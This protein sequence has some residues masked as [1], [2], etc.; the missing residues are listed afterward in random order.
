MKKTIISKAIK[1]S[2]LYAA[3]FGVSYATTC[4]SDIGVPALP[5]EISGLYT[6]TNE[7]ACSD[8]NITPSGMLNST[9]P[10]NTTGNFFIANEGELNILKGGTASIRNYGAAAISGSYTSYRIENNGQLRN[11]GAIFDSKIIN[12]TN[13][14]LRN[15]ANSTMYRTEIDNKGLFYNAGLISRSFESSP[16][17]EIANSGTIVN[18]GTIHFQYTGTLRNGGQLVNSGNIILWDYNLENTGSIVNTGSLS[19]ATVPDGHSAEL[20]NFGEILGGGSI[21]IG[22]SYLGV[23]VRN[24][25][26]LN[27]SVIDVTGYQAHYPSY[28]LE[29]LYSS[30]D[31]YAF[32]RVLIENTGTLISDIHFNPFTKVKNSGEWIGDALFENQDVSLAQLTNLDNIGDIDLTDASFYFDNPDSS[33]SGKSLNLTN[34]RG[35]VIGLDTV[36]YKSDLFALVVKDGKLVANFKDFAPA[37]SPVDEPSTQLISI[38]SII[39]LMGGSLL[40]KG[41]AGY[42]ATRQRKMVIS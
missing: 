9:A 6:S 29:R 10:L 28:L 5:S 37:T 33:L 4:P 21:N 42:D 39:M 31:P 25:G 18:S 22:E 34:I 26:T 36:T 30:T 12:N 27:A 19:L 1:G 32:Y 14:V 20:I 2:I 17:S 35:S 41:F 38:V 24:F 7:L 13:G 8:V 15:E 11:Q 3:C 23:M 40:Q 16:G